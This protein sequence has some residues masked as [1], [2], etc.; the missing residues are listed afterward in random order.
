MLKVK[1]KGKKDRIIPI[2]PLMA[3]RLRTWRETA[4]G[5][6][7]ARSMGR[8]QVRTLNKSLSSVGVFNIVRKYGE[9]I[10]CPRLAPHDLRRTFAELRR[11]AGEPITRIS[12]LLGHANSSVTE[13]YLNLELDLDNVRDSM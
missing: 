3:E 1:G 9:L 4:G 10:E 6:R 2:Q 12:R 5:G 7:I 11:A 13:K 8:A